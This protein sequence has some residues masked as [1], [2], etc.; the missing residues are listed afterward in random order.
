MAVT[1][2][3]YLLA[4]IPSKKYFTLLKQF[5]EAPAEPRLELSRNYKNRLA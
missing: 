1:L 4:V 3:R 2:E 5:R